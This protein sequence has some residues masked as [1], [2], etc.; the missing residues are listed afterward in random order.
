MIKRVLIA[1]LDWGLGHATR[2]IPLIR[3]LQQRQCDIFIAGSGDAQVLLQ[4]EFPS[5]TFLDLPGYQPE[6]STGS[7]V[8]SMAKQL[9]K[10]VRVIRDEHE[11]L[12]RHVK[13]HNID[14]VISDNR[15]GCW[16]AKVPSIFITHQSNILMPKRF[17]WLSPWVRRRNHALIR[18]FAQCWIPDVPGHDSL[19]GSLIAFGETSA[20][21]N[22]HYIGPQ[23]RFT[24]SEKT[25]TVFDVVCVFSGPEPQRSH[26]EKKVVD[27]VKAS[28][29]KYFIVRGLPSARE[30]QDDRNC[31][32]FLKGE[33]LQKVL[34][35]STCVIARSGFSTVMDL[36]ALRRRAIFVPTPGQ[37]EQEYLATRLMNQGVAYAQEQHRFDFASAWQESKKYSGFTALPASGALLQKA[38]DVLFDA[39]GTMP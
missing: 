5:L 24:P 12:E 17:G 35:Q 7:M 29:L 33:A 13:Q 10:F 8:W 18:R 1:P 4:E 16:S 25:E 22:V 23:S 21:K 27:Q 20:L 26:F 6:Y 9:P 37:T 34:E 2:C 31:V 32:N 39:K 19:A 38:L 3:A 14:L 15:Y 30:Q 11:L 36:A 28:G